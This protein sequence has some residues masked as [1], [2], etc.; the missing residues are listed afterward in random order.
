MTIA[1]EIMVIG[2][3]ASAA[4]AVVGG[5]AAAN[6]AEYQSA[7]AA[8]NA[9]IAQQN[10]AY[11][12]QQG[13]AEQV[14][15][16]MKQQQQA[17]KMKAVQGA[18]GVDVNEGTASDVAQGEAS[19]NAV[20]QTRIAQGANA[21]ARNFQ[22]QSQDLSAESEMYSNSASNALFSSFI[23]GVSS[24]AGKWSEFKNVGLIS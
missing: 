18:S 5:M 13:Q 10:A 11:A 9:Q 15:A 21:K 7:I 17:G 2:A 6:Q 1:P 8:R 19:I 12:T 20:D 14:D 16:A 24:V 23:G 4:S 3:I 22:N